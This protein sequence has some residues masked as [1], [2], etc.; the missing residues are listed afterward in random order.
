MNEDIRHIFT[1][2]AGPP[3]PEELPLVPTVALGVYQEHLSYALN[4]VSSVNPAIIAG[5]HIDM[6][7][8][9][10]LN[11]VAYSD[12]AH[13]LVGINAG[14]AIVL[15][16]IASWLLSH[17]NAF[18]SIGDPSKETQP[19]PLD[20]SLLMMSGK[21][22]QATDDTW[23]DQVALPS[24]RTRKHFVTYM[25]MVAWD[26]LLF[27]ELGHINR[28]HIPYLSSKTVT[29][30]PTT[31]WFE[32][33]TEGLTK[34]ES[35]TRRLLEVD[36]DGYA[37]R[38]LSGAPILNGLQ[39]ARF[40]ALGDSESTPTSWDWPNAYKTWLK[41]VGLLFQL[42][43]II[44]HNVSIANP[45][46]THP[47][48]D[49]RMQVLVN[50]IYQRWSEVIPDRAY[51]IELTR[52]ASREMKDIVRLGILPSPPSRFDQAYSSGYK[53]TVL[54]LWGALQHRAEDLNEMTTKRKVEK[55]K[56]LDKES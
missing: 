53:D 6:V 36:A 33:G 45:Q 52:E 17:P 50:S 9:L 46:R 44:E 40:V 8:A 31:A 15:P 1:T 43:A 41:P 10:D 30:Q 28:C 51:F 49:I 39:M 32:F 24:D 34:E 19:P 7:D 22:S 38:I 26:F 20:Y 4:Q 47:H 23:P 37:G 42:M 11:A 5:V 16:L 48:P 29:S 35:E 12:G 21:A 3:L 56:A 55:R 13:E 2:V 54:D 14:F 27:H 18:P 25:S